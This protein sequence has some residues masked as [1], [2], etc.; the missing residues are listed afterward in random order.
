[1]L[2]KLRATETT[3]ACDVADIQ[4]RFRKPVETLS[5]VSSARSHTPHNAGKPHW[6]GKPQRNGKCPNSR[7]AIPQGKNIFLQWLNLKIIRLYGDIYPRGGG[8]GGRGDGLKGVRAQRAASVPFHVRLIVRHV[9]ASPIK[10][11][12]EGARSSGRVAEI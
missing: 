6:S 7:P 9:C 3:R 10:P 11:L 1:M 4:N 8:G 5:A 2:R 12:C